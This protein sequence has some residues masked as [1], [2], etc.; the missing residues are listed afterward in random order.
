MKSIRVVFFIGILFFINSQAQIFD[1][2]SPAETGLSSQR[3]ERLSGA[4]QKHIDNGE[5]AGAVTLIGRHGNIAHLQSQ[6]LLSIENQIPMRDDAIFRIASMTKL[7]TSI[8]V[9]ILYEEGHFFLTDPVYKIIPEFKDIRVAQFD[10]DGNITKTVPAKTP[11]TIQH[12]FTHTAGFLYGGLFDGKYKSLDNL[13]A[14]ANLDTDRQDLHSFVTE[15]AKLPL[16][17]EPGTKWNYGFSTDVLGYLVEVVSGKKLNV[18]CKER[19]FDPLGMKDTDFFVP[20]DKMDRFTT[21]YNYKEKK[22]IPVDYAGN[23]L[24]DKI[25]FGCSGGGGLVSTASDYAVIGQMLLNDGNYNG[26]QLLGKK[27]VELMMTNHLTG[28]PKENWFEPYAGF[29][30]GGAIIDDVGLYGE[31]ASKGYF[32]WAGY[33]NTYF[34]VDPAEDMFAILMVQVL[35]FTHV[36]L[37]KRFKNLVYQSI[38]E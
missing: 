21:L 12:L 25:P 32:W 17:F 26:V 27:T 35:P 22:L 19:I 29:G 16:A 4:I 31:Y 28:I 2:V 30:L 14:N 24:F 3:L 15:L 18:F 20:N 38:I 7:V 11:V 34:F 33:F 13:Y 6:G 9:M 36:D 10:E 37:M 8:A 23:T 5:I 1:K